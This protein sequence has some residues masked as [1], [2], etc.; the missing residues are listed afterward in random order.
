MSA[1]TGTAEGIQTPPALWEPAGDP[2][3]SGINLTVVFL[4]S[5]GRWGGCKTRGPRVSVS[6]PSAPSQALAVCPSL[7]LPVLPQ[8]LPCF[9]PLC[10]SAGVAGPRGV[11]TIQATKTFLES[12]EIFLLTPDRLFWEAGACGRDSE[13]RRRMRKALQ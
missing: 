12:S 1:S 13:R 8:A 2:P 7:V 6:F 11:Q 5:S 9:F 10:S 4:P 3:Y